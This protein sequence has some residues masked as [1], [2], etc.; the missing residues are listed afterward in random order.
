MTTAPAGSTSAYPSIAG[1]LLRRNTFPPW[2][3]SGREQVQQTAFDHF[4]GQSGTPRFAYFGNRRK[5]QP[6]SDFWMIGAVF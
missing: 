6:L 5:G 2:A 3:T 4:F 1:E